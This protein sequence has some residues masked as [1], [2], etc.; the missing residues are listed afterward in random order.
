M[1]ISLR[2][3]KTSDVIA[4]REIF[5]NEKVAEQ[6]D[7]GFESISTTESAT[8]KLQEIIDKNKKGNYYEFAIIYKNKF[9]GL[10]CLEKPSQNKKIFTLGYVVGRKYWGK[11]I[12]TEAVKQVLKFGFNKL[13]LK[14]IVADNDEDNPASARVL[15]KNGFKFIKKIQKSRHDKNKKINVLF[16]ERRTP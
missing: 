10:V 8:K 5:S 9:V 14:K 4:F 6:L 7:D 15:E 11:G 3:P 16:W 2:K 13:K 12:A 1:K